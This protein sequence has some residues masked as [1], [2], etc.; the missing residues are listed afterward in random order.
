MATIAIRPDLEVPREEIDALCERRNI[1]WLA[2]FGSVLREDFRPESDI[3]VI[4]DFAPDRTPSLFQRIKIEEELSEIFHG[5]TIHFGTRNSLNKW[6]RDS[7][8][9]E[10]R[11]VYD[12]A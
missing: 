6:I 8:L 4:V 10:A 9:Q 5:R 12:A 11:V 1:I 7:V 3:D 2:V